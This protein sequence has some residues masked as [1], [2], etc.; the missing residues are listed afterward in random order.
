MNGKVDT[1]K[2]VSKQYIC[3]CIFL[4]FP[5]LSI[6]DRF[7]ANL[8]ITAVKIFFNN[9]SKKFTTYWTPY[10]EVGALLNL[11]TPVSDNGISKVL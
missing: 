11:I 3:F 5:N 8:L 1:G 10:L 4:P 7:A 9:C 6:I 2:N